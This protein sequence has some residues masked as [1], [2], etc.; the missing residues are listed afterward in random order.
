[1]DMYAKIEQHRLNYIKFNQIQIRS[2]LCSRLASGVLCDTDSDELG[3]SIV[4][5][6]S[7]RV[8]PRQTFELYQDAMSIA[9][10]W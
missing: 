2:N 5:P 6:S 9:M 7:Y 4:A 8:N 10:K 3:P 1:M